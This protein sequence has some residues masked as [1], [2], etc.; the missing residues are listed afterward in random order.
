MS[1]SAIAGV[2]VSV[3][4]GI[5]EEYPEARAYLESRLVPEKKEEFMSVKDINVDD[6][7][8]VFDGKNI[9]EYFKGG[10]KDLQAPVLREV[11]DA[12]ARIGLK[13]VPAMPMF[14]YKAIGDQWVPVDQTDVTVERWCGADAGADITYERNTVGEHMSEID[15]GKPRVE[16]WL[17]SIFD[18]S[19]EPSA[20]GCTV[21][22]VTVDLSTEAS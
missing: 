15:N 21:R 9:Y 10:A 7:A 22:N 8:V 5:T 14:V 20:G 16:E 2:M 11:Y 3:L 4:V 17:E 19:Y 6:A 1:G 18:E 13:D 12:Q